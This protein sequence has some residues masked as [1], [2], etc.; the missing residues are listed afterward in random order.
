MDY[1]LKLSNGYTTKSYARQQN[2][3]LLRQQN[4]NYSDSLQ[5][6]TAIASVKE[7]KKG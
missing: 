4:Q 7:A 2:P 1:N 6:V 5:K 3:L